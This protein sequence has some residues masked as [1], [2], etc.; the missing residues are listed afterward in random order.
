MTYIDDE[1][2]N[3]SEELEINRDNLTHVY[4]REPFMRLTD[5]YMGTMSEEAIPNLML[6]DVDDY[7]DWEDMNS[8]ISAEGVLV[9]VARI[10]KRAFRGSDLIGRVGTDRFVVFMKGIRNTNILEER[11]AYV[12]QT[13]RDVWKDTFAKPSWK[14]RSAESIQ[15]TVHRLI[16]SLI[17]CRAK[18]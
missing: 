11:A 8:Q 17:S 6:V 3:N 16:S 18:M 1:S 14:I 2:K 15:M 7:G 13:V 5:E 10:L 12:C 4:N 9:E